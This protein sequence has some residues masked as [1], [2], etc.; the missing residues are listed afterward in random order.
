MLYSKY[1]DFSPQ[2]IMT[3]KY[4]KICENFLKFAKDNQVLE[5][6]KRNII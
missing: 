2:K 4:K 5:K 1:S 3:E 6:M